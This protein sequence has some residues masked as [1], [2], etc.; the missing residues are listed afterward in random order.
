[1]FMVCSCQVEGTIRFT[2]Q[3]LGVDMDSDRPAHEDEIN[4]TPEMVSAGVRVACLY[5][6]REDGWDEVVRSI[7]SEMRAL[8]GRLLTAGNVRCANLGNSFVSSM[9][10]Y[11]LNHS[12]LGDECI[13]IILCSIPKQG[14]HPNRGK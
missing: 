10:E 3:A 13:S 2:Y 6:M 12:R 14:Q 9:H 7:Y 1:M 5:D 8:E 11:G 4:I